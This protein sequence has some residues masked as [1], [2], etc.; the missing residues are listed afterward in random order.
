MF[1]VEFTTQK[2]DLGCVQ[3]QCLLHI[4]NVNQSLCVISQQ[5]KVFV[6][7]L[8]VSYYNDQV[9]SMLS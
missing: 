2:R 6:L 4:E 3:V 9:C 7:V 5:T 8:I 1:G